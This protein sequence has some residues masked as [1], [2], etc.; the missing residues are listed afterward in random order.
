M[1]PLCPLNQSLPPPYTQSPPHSANNPVMQVSLDGYWSGYLARN[2]SYFLHSL[3]SSGVRAEYLRSQYP[4]KTFPNHFSIVTVSCAH[5][6]V[7]TYA[8]TYVSCG[9][10]CMLHH[11]H[12]VRMYV[13]M[14]WLLLVNVCCSVNAYHMYCK[15]PGHT[16]C[17]DMPAWPAL[18]AN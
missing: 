2:R 11:G 4:T 8:H 5:M 12:G 15:P 18:W 16:A 14:G 6:Y 9:V 17:L 10:E 1:Q 13:R 3:A 7:R